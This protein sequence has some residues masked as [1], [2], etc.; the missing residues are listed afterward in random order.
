MYLQYI[1]R[2][3]I[4]EIFLAET[5]QEGFVEAIEVEGREDASIVTQ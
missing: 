5:N 4:L 3:K 1:E 2:A